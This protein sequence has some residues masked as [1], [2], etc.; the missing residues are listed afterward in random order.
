MDYHEEVEHSQNNILNSYT[1][2]LVDAIMRMC[3]YSIINR[4]SQYVD[5]HRVGG[6]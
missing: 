1:R 6:H 3:V 5:G 2:L 4:A